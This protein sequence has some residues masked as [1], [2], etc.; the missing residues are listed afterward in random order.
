MKK[1]NKPP[2]EAPVDFLIV[3]AL[4]LELD[5]VLAQFDAPVEFYSRDM[6]RPSYCAPIPV[7]DGGRYRVVAMTVFGMGPA[8]AALAAAA[9]INHWQ[10]GAVLMVGI[11][12]GMP[13]KKGIKLGDVLVA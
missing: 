8:E 1:V 9:M 6:L 7:D 10:P 2:F 12:A 11:A 5:A 4:E 3:T 13:N